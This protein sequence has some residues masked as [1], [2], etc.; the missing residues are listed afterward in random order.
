[1]LCNGDVNLPAVVTDLISG[2]DCGKL[3]A[4]VKL[5]IDKFLDQPMKSIMK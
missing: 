4:V 5:M 3:G 1:M 2:N